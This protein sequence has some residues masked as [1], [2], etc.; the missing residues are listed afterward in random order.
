MTKKEQLKKTI[1]EAF[2]SEDFSLGFDLL[3]TLEHYEIAHY[4]TENKILLNKSIASHFWNEYCLLNFEKVFSFN[5]SETILNWY[6]KDL[7][8]FND[9]LNRYLIEKESKKFLK[10][11]KRNRAFLNEKYFSKIQ[12]LVWNQKD[13]TEVEAMKI[14]QGYHLELQQ[15]IV[16]DW[17]EIEQYDFNEI[18]C[19][20]TVWVDESFI[21]TEEAGDQEILRWIYNYIVSFLFSKKEI[22]KP[23]TEKEFDK[24]FIETIYKA[25]K[26]KFEFFFESVKRWL[27]FET[28]Y[29]TSFC[30]DDNFITVIENGEI[31]FDFA[32]QEKY[33]QYQNDTN[34]Y[35][36]NERR[37]L[38]SAAEEMDSQLKK[39][40][41]VI[42][43]TDEDS[44]NINGYLHLQ[45]LKSVMILD[46]LQIEQVKFDRKE[47]NYKAL[48]QGLM[49]YSHNRQIRYSEPM[50]IMKY[51]GYQWHEAY[52]SNIH[53]GE[54][55][56][57]TNPPLAYIYE[58]RNE[59]VKFYSEAAEYMSNKEIEAMISHFTYSFTSTYTFNP[60]YTRYSVWETPLLNIG[61]TVFTPMCFFTSNDWFYGMIQRGLSIYSNDWHTNELEKTSKEMES[62]LAEKFIENK[63]NTFVFND[64]NKIDGD[65]DIFV[66][67]GK[68]QLLI[69]LKRTRLRLDLAADYREQMVTDLKASGQINQVILS[70]KENP[71]LG[72]EIYENPKKWIVTTS[73]ERLL[74][75]IDDCLKVNYF[76]LIWALRYMKF[77][78]LNDL[79]KYIEDDR[80][81]R[82]CEGLLEIEV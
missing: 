25:E 79:A 75:E 40:T 69:Q 62:F 9:E 72:I 32:S 48:I 1:L 15:N 64:S 14:L 50:R 49:T 59:F 11:I 28:T 63:F 56:G 6:L 42:P 77:K 47:S 22:N 73:F 67:D 76:D 78:T 27:I 34:R 2:T 13:R 51:Q 23:L 29:L 61:N 10:S 81:F 46:D 66:N 19:A 68:T 21:S 12:S 57:L 71:A 65:I 20:L 41:L 38:R 52:I 37:Y 82:D 17:Q 7:S 30:F 36:V 53:N 26:E 16:T 5:F 74:T 35:L 44:Q 3:L 8:Q 31:R 70:L 55:E 24:L 4:L 39:G 80:P 58:N 45:Y 43:G 60:F 33:E 54:L 18:L